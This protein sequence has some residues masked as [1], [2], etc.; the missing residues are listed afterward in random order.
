ML[1]V[2]NILF[3]R[4]YACVCM[5]VSVSMF[6]VTYLYRILC[7]VFIGTAILISIIIDMYSKKIVVDIFF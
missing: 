5:F 4:S 7:L 6:L 2:V 1:S 3:V